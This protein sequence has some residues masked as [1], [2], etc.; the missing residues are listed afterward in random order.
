MTCVR[1][2]RAGPMAAAFDSGLLTAL[3]RE[4]AEPETDDTAAADSAGH[5]SVNF[6]FTPAA[7]QDSRPPVCLRDTQIED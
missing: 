7:R 5:P 2:S 1:Q 3:T 4:D 6:T